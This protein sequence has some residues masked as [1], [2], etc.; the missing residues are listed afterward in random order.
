MQQMLEAVDVQFLVTLQ[1]D[2][3]VPVALVIPEEQVLAVCGIDIFPVFQSR[4][5]GGEGWVG[6][7]FVSDAVLRKKVQCPAA[8]FKPVLHFLFR[9]APG[10][11]FQAGQY[12]R[13]CHLERLLA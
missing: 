8:P 9:Q 10:S 12:R 5:H 7:Q 3:I 11:P 6:I 13:H 1:D 4:L 2:K